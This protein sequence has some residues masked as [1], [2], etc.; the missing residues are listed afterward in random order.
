M[1]I[2]PRV[3]V[4][5]QRLGP[6]HHARL[7]AAGARTPL[8]AIEFSAVDKTYA[9]AKIEDAQRSGGP[10]C[11]RMPSTLPGRVS[12][13]ASM[14]RWAASSRTRSRSPGGRSRPRWQRSCGACDINGPRS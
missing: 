11:S 4:C 1:T 5:F 14:T 9:W 7:S 13:D 2:A 6:C 3:A 8:A 10:C 12:F